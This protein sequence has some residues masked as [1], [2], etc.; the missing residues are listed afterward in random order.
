M[1]YIIKPRQMG[2]ST[3]TL[4][5]WF[6]YCILVPHT[7]S[8]LIT[9]RAAAS[10]RMFRLV[11]TWYLELPPDIK[12]RV[13]RGMD[14]PQVSRP[15]VLNRFEMVFAGNDSR[16]FSESAGNPTALR[17]ATLSHIHASEIS[18]WPGDVEEAI[19]AIMGTLIPGGTFRLE[20]TP[21]LAG[22]WA[23]QEWVSALDGQSP[24]IPVFIPWWIDPANELDPQTIDRRI[25]EHP[26]GD[27]PYSDEE[28]RGMQAHGW[29]PAQIAWRRVMKKNHRSAFITEF[30]EDPMS[31]WL[32]KGRLVF[33]LENL[34]AAF[35]QNAD[36]SAVQPR[37]WMRF[38][39]PVP[40]ETYLV[41]VDPAEGVAGGDFTGIHV[42]SAAG[43]QVAE[44]AD[45]IRP[46]QT[47]AL[48]R[49][50]DYPIAT[51]TIE[52]NNHGHTLIELLRDSGLPLTYDVDDKPGLL[53]TT[54]SKATRIAQLDR[55][56]AEHALVLHSPRLYNQLLQFKYDERNRA[57]GPESGGDNVLQHDDLVSALLLAYATLHAGVAFSTAP[58]TI[59][60]IDLS[61]EKQPSSPGPLASIAPPQVT[62]PDACP[63]CGGTLRPHLAVLGGCQFCGAPGSQIQNYPT[64]NV[65]LYAIPGR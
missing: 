48:L 52:R 15:Q 44:Y 31:G 51:I 43:E 19:A 58:L 23:Y 62:I 59:K 16:F 27:P 12:R 21:R 55:G 28:L 18:S 40:G 50:L 65:P 7:T 17:S 3:L 29:T 20:T 36:V 24:W 33:D 46:H 38:K 35:P 54:A 42:F 22:S 5:E 30:P 45:Q 10:E 2:I 47:N 32:T 4:A 39:E 57:G 9:H 41:A 26:L 63:L 60:H 56:L 13:N 1:D 14:D 34:K 49:Q 6:A 25:A 37:G 8:A 11:K 61:G 64:E 53:T